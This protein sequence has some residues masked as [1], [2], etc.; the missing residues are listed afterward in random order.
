MNIWWCN[1]SRTWSRESDVG[2]VCS[3]DDTSRLQY[4]RTVGDARKGDIVLH[5]RSGYGIVAVSRASADAISYGKGARRRICLYSKSGGGWAFPSEYHLL[6]PPIHK[7]AIIDEL[8]ALNMPNSP[9][10]RL[11]SGRAQ[12]REAYFMK[13]SPAAL[14]VVIN[15]GKNCAWPAWASRSAQNE[16]GVKASTRGVTSSALEGMAREFSVLTRTRSAPLRR[17]ALEASHGVCEV[18]ETDYSRVMDGAG[19]RVLQVHHKRQM[20]LMSVPAKTSLPDLAVLCANC[21]VLIH[22]NPKR[23]MSVTQLRK[24]LRRPRN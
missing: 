23:A 20:S 10:L 9:V 3:S 4:R 11:A 6:K 5:Y 2:V 19:I 7:G 18:C 24:K 16:R 8:L 22:L 15:A 13:I 12:V 1:Q 14:K 21:H 17:A